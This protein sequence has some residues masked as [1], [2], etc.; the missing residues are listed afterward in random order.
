MSQFDFGNLSSPLSGA[1]FIDG[2]LEP[3]RDALHSGHSGS[4]RPSYVVEGMWWIDTSNTPWVA[5]VF[6]GSDDIIVGTLDPSTLVFTPSASGPIGEDSVGTASIQDGSV[7]NSKLANMAANTVKANAT[8]GA[9]APTDLAMG[10]S[11]ILARLASGNII[12]ATITQIIDLIAGTPAQGDTLYR[13]G[14]SWLRLAK[15]TALQVLRM[16]AGATAPEWASPMFATSFVGTLTTW[17][18]STR[19]TFAHGLGVVPKVFGATLRCQTADVGYSVGDEIVP[20]VSGGIGY[21]YVVT[22]D[23]TNI[24]VI[25]SNAGI[26]LYNKTTPAGAVAATVSRWQIKPFAYA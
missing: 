14:S 16:N 8:A 12:A 4:S 17:T 19:F 13:N 23:A 18:N 6:Q 7:T 9:A 11:S 24:Y 5:K 3:W 10:A 15:G 1:S 25:T 21:N 26:V 20:I 22:A 2:N